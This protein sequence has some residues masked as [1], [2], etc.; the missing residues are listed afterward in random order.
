MSVG[1]SGL[2]GRIGNRVQIPNGTATVSE[3]AAAHGESRSLGAIPEKAVRQ[4]DEAQ[5]QDNC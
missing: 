4:A 5:S 1:L 2:H 3:E